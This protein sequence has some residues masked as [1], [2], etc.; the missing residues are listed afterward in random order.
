MWG[1]NLDSQLNRAGGGNNNGAKE[2]KQRARTTTILSPY[3]LATIS[4][5]VAAIPCRRCCMGHVTLA[6]CS[7]G[8]CFSNYELQQLLSVS[9]LPVIA[10]CCCW[11]P[12]KFSNCSSNTLLKQQSGLLELPAVSCKVSCTLCR[13]F[14]RA[15]CSGCCPCCVTNGGQSLARRVT[16]PGSDNSN[17]NKKL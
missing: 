3:A 16:N 6:V 17:N 8:V 11:P 10:W 9:V 4:D 14:Q 2:H 5:A 1:Y 15:H 13:V 7:C 12:C